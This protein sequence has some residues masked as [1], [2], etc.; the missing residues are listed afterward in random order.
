PPAVGH[1]GLAVC[2]RLPH[3][4]CSNFL[5]QLGHPRQWQ[6]RR[7]SMNTAQGPEAALQA[8]F[9]AMTKPVAAEGG[10][11]GLALP[12]YLTAAQ[13]KSTLQIA[14]KAK[15]TVKGSAAAAAG[16]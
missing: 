14:A 11:V 9:E 4:V 2:R 15:L 10:E 13:V 8:T 1:A 5:P 3:V 16:G 6:A 7:V 12:S